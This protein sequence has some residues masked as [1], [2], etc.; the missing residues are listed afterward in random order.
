LRLLRRAALTVATTVV[1]YWLVVPVGVAL[2]ATHRPRAHVAS[3]ALG[4]PYERVTL[5]TRDG[6]ELAGW[7]VRSQNGG[8]V[9]SYPTRAGNLRQARMLV[10]HGYGVLL[11]DARGYDGSQGDANLFGWEGVNDVDAA[12][13][14]LS[15]QPDVDRARI[16]GI[17]FSVGGEVML[18][19]AARNANLRAVVSEGAG[20]RSF[21][22]DLL[23]G[24]RGWFSLPEALVQSA[25]VAVLTGT[26]PPPSLEDVMRHIAPRHALLIYGE[27]GQ[28]SETLNRDYYLAAAVGV[29][30][31]WA[32]PEA[33]HVG[34]IDARPAQYERR[35][36]GFFD[37]WLP[38]R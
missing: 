33:T 8:A 23:R 36:T 10:R 27:K 26:P 24:A 20:A 25:A 13:S 16:G 1:G 32:V 21:R 7:Y 9:V 17:G 19:A 14:F 18:Q 30:E 12:V 5:E 11:V 2:M 38:A 6:L 35:V 37:R 3:A 22:E 31:L 15:A 28:E 4:R 29:A 34:A